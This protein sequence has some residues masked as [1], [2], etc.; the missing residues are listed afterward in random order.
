MSSETDPPPPV[1]RCAFCADVIGMYERCISVL[2][3]EVRMVSL[4]AAPESLPAATLYHEACYDLV[5][6]R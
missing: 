6:R 1:P 3:N 5:G 2:G 4:A